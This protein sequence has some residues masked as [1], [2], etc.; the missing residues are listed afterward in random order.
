MRL[1][2]PHSRAQ[3]LSAVVAALFGLATLF[4]GGRV[5]FGLGEAGYVV[6]PAVLLF[7]TIMGVFYLLAA[8]LIVRSPEVGRIAAGAIAIVNLAVLTLIVVHRASGGIVANETLGAM[9]LRT[10]VWLGIFALMSRS[11]RRNVG[12]S[13]A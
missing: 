5:L 12:A 6:V 13:V 8:V 9:T 4:A 11:L 2:C 7:N 10:V 1:Q 3:R